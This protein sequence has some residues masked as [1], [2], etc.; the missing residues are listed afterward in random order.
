[1]DTCIKIT[2]KTH[3]NRTTKKGVEQELREVMGEDKG[4]NNSLKEGKELSKY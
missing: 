1:M 2:L 4:M 3:E